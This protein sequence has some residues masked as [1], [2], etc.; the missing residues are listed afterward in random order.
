MA[1]FRC[2]RNPFFVVH[3]LQGPSI[4]A[5][6]AQRLLDCDRVLRLL[7]VCINKNL[8]PALSARDSLRDGSVYMGTPG[9]AYAFIRLAE[10]EPNLLASAEL[11]ST[12]CLSIADQLLSE[13]L[14][15]NS[16]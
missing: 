15:A 10:M 9:I 12:G 16:R 1:D 8:I 6:K 3:G 2:F 13:T 4:A 5:L 11:S 14:P 7:C